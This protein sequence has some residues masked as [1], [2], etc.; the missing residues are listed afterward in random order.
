ML[1]H[2]PDSDIS[3]KSLPISVLIHEGLL[4]TLLQAR[5]CMF[6]AVILALLQILGT[7]LRC[8]PLKHNFTLPVGDL[9]YCYNLK[10]LVIAAV[11]SRVALDGCIWIMPHF[12]VW[13][14]QLR[15]AHKIAIT[16]IFGL[17]LMYI[18]RPTFLSF[19]YHVFLLTTIQKYSARR[20]SYW[21]PL[22]KRF[23]WRS[24][25][26]H[27][28]CFHVGCSSVEHGHHRCLLS[29]STSDI[30]MYD[31]THLDPYSDAQVKTHHAEPGLTSLNHS[32]NQ[33][34]CAQQPTYTSTYTHIP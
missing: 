25:Y 3:V 30:R 18:F 19:T 22:H 4:L 10:P 8:R 6:A 12:V 16:V 21:S 5:L 2:T 1:A 24:H 26:W 20:L 7:L 13:R 32:Y 31:T 11:A 23:L 34:L 9:R 29:P 28:C 15:R 33:D 17:G 14:L 27:G